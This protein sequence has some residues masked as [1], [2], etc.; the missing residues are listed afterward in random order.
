[1]LGHRERARDQ[2][3]G[4]YEAIE[5]ADLVEALGGEAEAERHFHR[6]RV[7]QVCNMPMVVA[8]EQPALRLR[9]LEDRTPRGDPQIGALDQHEAAAHGI[10]VDRG[11]DRFLQCPGHERIFDR[12]PPPAG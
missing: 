1:M 9:H 8:A 2:L 12:R 4:I 7:G 3:L 6:D 11:D 5:K 10:A